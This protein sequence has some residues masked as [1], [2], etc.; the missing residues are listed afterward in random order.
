MCSV[1]KHGLWGNMQVK[2]SPRQAYYKAS[3]VVSP[4]F[5]TSKCLLRGCCAYCIRLKYLSPWTTLELWDR[6]TGESH[7]DVH[8]Y[9][10]TMQRPHNDHLGIIASHR[11]GL[12]GQ[13]VLNAGWFA[14]QYKRPV[15]LTRQVTFACAGSV[16][17]QYYKRPVGL[18][19]G[20]DL[21]WRW[22]RNR[23]FTVYLNN[24]EF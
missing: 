17:F 14:F 23:G 7:Q 8:A 1:P 2:S 6:E 4:T 20:G 11:R 24:R 19:K 16:A 22:S 21:S 10:G 3:N 15:G 5:S 13:V 9:R 12:A 18:S